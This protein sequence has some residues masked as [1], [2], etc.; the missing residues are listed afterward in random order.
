MKTVPPCIHSFVRAVTKVT[1][2]RC[3]VAEEGEQDT[4]H[5]TTFADPL[6][7][8]ARARVYAI[9]AET[10]KAN[11]DYVFDFHLRRA[12]EAKATGGTPAGIAGAHYFAVWGGIDA[13]Q[14]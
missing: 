11:S 6:T 5:L 13:D 9:E 3:V 4:V 1:G 7:E 10:I 2:V 12:D 14:G 8:E